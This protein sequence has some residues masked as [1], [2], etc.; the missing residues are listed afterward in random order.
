[1]GSNHVTQVCTSADQKWSDMKRGEG[2]R[3]GGRKVASEVPAIQ[4]D[5]GGEAPTKKTN[6]SHSLLLLQLLLARNIVAIISG[7][8]ARK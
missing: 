4:Q 6:F 1:M 3:G 5:E 8:I 2:V 7:N